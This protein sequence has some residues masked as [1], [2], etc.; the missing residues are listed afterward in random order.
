M[1]V[2]NVNGV[3]IGKGIPKICVPIC[4]ENRHEI[5]L[6]AQEIMEV[7]AESQCVDLVEWRVDYYARWRECD[8]VQ[9]VIQ[10]LKKILGNVPLLV[11]LRTM[12][13]G[14]RADILEGYGNWLK[15]VV[16]ECDIID[17]ECETLLRS[18]VYSWK[19]VKMAHNEGTRV[20]FSRHDRSRTPEQNTLDE[21]LRYMDGLGGDLIKLAVKPDSEADV[22]RLLI[23]AAKHSDIGECPAIT[24]SMGRLGAVSRLVGETVGSC[25]S[26]ASLRDGEGSAPGQLEAKQLHDILKFMHETSI[27]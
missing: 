16:S 14:G 4:K 11:T 2:V 27:K 22:R 6:M 3:E 12:K 9:E 20:L 7:R 1:N 26:F 24:I 15:A 5:L 18:Q 13:E 23:A 17:V 19:F 25:I 21:L 10:G 8:K